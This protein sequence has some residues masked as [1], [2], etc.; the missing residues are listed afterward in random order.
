MRGG[1]RQLLRLELREQMKQLEKN[2]SGQN[3]YLGQAVLQLHPPYSPDKLVEDVINAI[4]DRAFI[5]EDAP[6]RTREGICRP[7]STRQGAT[8]SRDRSDRTAGADH[9]QRMPVFAGEAGGGWRRGRQTEGG[10]QC[11]TERAA[12]HTIGSAG[13]SRI[14]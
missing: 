6:P 5:R 3:R 4:A 11:P 1:V 12:P 2:L 7:A 14:F 10:A 8:A 13:L 9:R